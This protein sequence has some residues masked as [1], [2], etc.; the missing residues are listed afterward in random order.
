[1]AL[2][3][4]Q[5]NL[6]AAFK[7]VGLDIKTI[8]ITLNSKADLENGKLKETQTNDLAVS[9]FLGE[10]ASQSAMLA[11]SGQKGDWCVRTDVGKVWVI[12]GNPTALA[13]WRSLEYPA[14][15]TPDNY[16]YANAYNTAKA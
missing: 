14:P 16:S 7:A 15:P 10:V 5:Q 8:L 9:D 2:T 11:L 6:D 3:Q 1:M 4:E 12:I 13:G